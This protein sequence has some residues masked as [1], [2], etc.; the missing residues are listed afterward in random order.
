LDKDKTFNIKE[1]YPFI[2]KQGFNK[3]TRVIKPV[4]EEGFKLIETKS[5]MEYT[6]H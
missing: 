4:Q 6:I 2:N 3:G 1:E 5:P